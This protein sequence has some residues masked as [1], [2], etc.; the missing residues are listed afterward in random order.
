MTLWNRLSSLAKADAHGV[1]DALE[2]PALVLRQHLR[3]A[4][5]ELQRK[6]CRVEALRNE[7]EA[8]AKEDR[9]LQERLNE[10]DRDVELA[11][12]SD[13]EELARFTIKR[14]LLIRRRSEEIACQVESQEDERSALEETLEQ[15]RAELESLEQ[16]VKAKLARLQRGEDAPQLWQEES[17]S[18]QEIE[19]ELLRRRSE[20]DEVAR[21]SSGGAS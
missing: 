18:D 17:V 7:G 12:A 20:G 4:Q 10:L 3:E 13:K 5:S 2:E 16:R 8:L 14:V 1:V 11:L 6:E 21:S 9:R 19:L 15:Q